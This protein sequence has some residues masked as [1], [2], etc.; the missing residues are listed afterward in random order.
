MA[1]ADHHGEPPESDTTFPP[2]LLSEGNVFG[3]VPQL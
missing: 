2:Y 3:N 1:T